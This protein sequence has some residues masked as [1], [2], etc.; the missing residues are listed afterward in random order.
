MNHE[1]LNTNHRRD[2][3]HASHEDGTRCEAGTA[4]RSREGMKG[5]QDPPGTKEKVSAV[6]GT[7]SS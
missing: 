5:S 6:A 1:T 2:N 4:G 7:P 3:R